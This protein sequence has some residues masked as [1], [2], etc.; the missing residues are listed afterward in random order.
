MSGPFPHQ[1]HNGKLLGFCEL[2]SP[3][4]DD[5]FDRPAPGQVAIRKNLPFYRKIGSH[6]RKASQQFE[7]V[8]KQHGVSNIVVF[9][10]HSP[11]IERHDLHLTISGLAAPDGKRIFMLGRKMQE[12]VHEAARKVDLFLWIDAQKRTLQYASV[13]DAPHQRSALDLLGL[14]PEDPLQAHTIDES[15]Y[16]L[17]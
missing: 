11:E 7:A 8:N 4:D 3:R 13:N 15:E 14:D 10:S 17:V 5:V 2:K 9:V 16:P 6:I 1:R 12:Q